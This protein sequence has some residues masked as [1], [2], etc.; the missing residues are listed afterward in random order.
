MEHVMGQ[1]LPYDPDFDAPPDNAP[2]VQPSQSSSE[3]MFDAFG[4][5]R[6]FILGFVF[7]LMLMASIGFLILAS[8]IFS[9]KALS[10]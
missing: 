8:V 9:G 7:S 3:N 10:L 1:P 4:P 5:R 2:G 6:S